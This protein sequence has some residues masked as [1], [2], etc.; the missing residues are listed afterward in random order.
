MAVLAAVLSLSS[1]VDRA[2]RVQARYLQLQAR[3][4]EATPIDHDPMQYVCAGLINYHLQ[5]AGRLVTWVL[6][7]LWALAR[8]L[9]VGVTL[10]LADHQPSSIS[11]S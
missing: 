2:V 11:A 8:S 3:S 1:N 7:L 9:T 4:R 5:N 10:G 6:D